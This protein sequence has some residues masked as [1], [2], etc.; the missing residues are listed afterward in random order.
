MS[1]RAKGTST[2]PTLAEKRKQ[3]QGKKTKR[4]EEEI[5]AKVK[6]FPCKRFKLGTCE[7]SADEC[8]YSHNDSVANKN[9]DTE[10]MAEAAN[11]RQTVVINDAQ[12]MNVS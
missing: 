7:L 3:L 11:D 9:S 4:N 8:R 1:F 10:A 12:M 2:F 5:A 6:Q